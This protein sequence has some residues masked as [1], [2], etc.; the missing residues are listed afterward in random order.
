MSVPHR[1]GTTFSFFPD[2]RRGACRQKGW[3]HFRQ[4]TPSYLPLISLATQPQRPLPRDSRH[5]RRIWPHD[6]IRRPGRDRSTSRALPRMPLPGIAGRLWGRRQGPQRRSTRGVRSGSDFCPQGI[7]IGRYGATSE[8]RR[9]VRRRS[10]H[11]DRADVRWPP[12]PAVPP[13]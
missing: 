9:T 3:L 11:E 13:A 7:A 12:A 5:F 10:D 1:C 8:S 6:P 4:K 2:Y